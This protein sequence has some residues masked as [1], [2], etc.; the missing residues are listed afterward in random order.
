MKMDS[1]PHRS[2]PALLA[3]RYS[4][5][6]ELALGDNEIAA[7]AL[8]FVKACIGTLDELLLAVA[9]NRHGRNRADADAYKS[10]RRCFMNDWFKNPCGN[11]LE[12]KP[13]DL[14]GDRAIDP[15]A[16]TGA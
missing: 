6:C 10:V 9:A 3:L 2:M 14:A 5:Q 16:V 7:A 13:K 15:N 1:G 12:C 11:W 4:R 8:G